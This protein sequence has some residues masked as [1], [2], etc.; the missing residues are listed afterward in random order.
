MSSRCAFYRITCAFYYSCRI[1]RSVD[2]EYLT[3]T[4]L[5]DMIRVSLPT[6]ARWRAAEPLQGPPFLKIEGSIR[7]PKQE[8]QKWLDERTLG[9]ALPT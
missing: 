9:G 3:A 2:S 7:Y 1:I 8:V 5:A 4:E 6:L